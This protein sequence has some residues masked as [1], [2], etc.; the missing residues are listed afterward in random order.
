MQLRSGNV[1]AGDAAAAAAA[2]EPIMS[3]M[4]FQFRLFALSGFVAF[5]RLYNLSC[6]WLEVGFVQNPYGLKVI[7]VIV[8]G[9]DYD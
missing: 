7:P 4:T 5:E 3:I 6:A 9:A 1:D 8:V 2:A